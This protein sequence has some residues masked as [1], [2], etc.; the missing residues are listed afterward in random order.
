MNNVRN[1]IDFN[2]IK[3]DLYKH[4]TLNCNMNYSKTRDFKKSIKLQTP[5]PQKKRKEK[6]K[7]NLIN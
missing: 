3:V 2:K 7:I 6:K 5:P 4:V 1:I